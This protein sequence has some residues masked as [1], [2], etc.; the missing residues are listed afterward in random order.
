MIAA[1]LGATSEILGMRCFRD[2]DCSINFRNGVL[3]RG[4]LEWDLLTSATA[5]TYIKTDAQHPLHS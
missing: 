1:D 2:N 4:Q 3:R 5:S